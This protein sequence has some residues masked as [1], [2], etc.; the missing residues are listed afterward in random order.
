MLEDSASSSGRHFTFDNSGLI[1]PLLRSILIPSREYHMMS[2]T[3]QIP[4][5]HEQCGQAGVP[6]HN[7]PAFASPAQCNWA[8]SAWLASA[9]DRLR[10]E[11]ARADRLN[12]SSM[13]SDGTSTSAAFGLMWKSCFALPSTLLEAA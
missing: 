9:S 13:L 8:A 10:C 1:S 12:A 6:N 3:A 11:T 5:W 2:T 7:D 4:R